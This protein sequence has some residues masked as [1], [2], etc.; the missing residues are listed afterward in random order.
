MAEYTAYFN[1]EWVPLGDVKIDSNDRGFT[2]GDVIFDA[3]RTFNGKSFRMK[4]HVDRMYRSLKYV[5]IDPGAEDIG[6]NLPIEVGI[7]SDE[8]AAIEA[9]IEALPPMTH[10]SWVAEIKAATQAYED[11]KLELYKKGLEYSVGG[12][13]HP[14]VIAKEIEDFLYKGDIDREQTTTVSGGFG[15]GKWTRRV[16]RAY[17]PGQICNGAYQY[18]SIGPDVGY[19]FGVGVAMKHG[20]GYQAGYEGNPILGVT[21]DAGFG[22]SG[23][24]IETLAKYRIP[25]IMVVYNNNAWGTWAGGRRAGAHIAHAHLF[26]EG[27]RYDKMAEALG[28][29]G[30]YV[31]SPDE[32]KTALRRAWDV[33]VNESLPT[34]INCQAKKEFWD[35]GQYPPGMTG[36]TEP[37]CEAYAH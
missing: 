32:M 31:T 24:E 21:G 30:E 22:Y 11:K 14:A 1:G 2:V 7:V 6:R 16:L 25:G 37:G 33:A 9:L 5:R 10:D 35:R 17:R 12:V 34:V 36:T 23:M 28:G 8:R 4:E 18:G 27:V 19:L 29:H 26:Q 13:I 15:I 20:A 3:V